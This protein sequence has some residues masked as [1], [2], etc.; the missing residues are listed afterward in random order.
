MYGRHKGGKLYTTAHGRPRHDY[1]T[2]AGFDWK[3]MIC[4]YFGNE[5]LTM[6][7]KAYIYPSDHDSR[8]LGIISRRLLYHFARDG[9]VAN[10]NPH[11]DLLNTVFFTIGSINLYLN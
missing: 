1:K 11:L 3:Q 8:T 7:C 5:V 2:V 10:A 6:T 4:S 9:F